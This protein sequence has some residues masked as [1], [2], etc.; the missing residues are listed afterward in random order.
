AR[1]GLPTTPGSPAA[2][3]RRVA[4]ALAALSGFALAYLFLIGLG[5][6]SIPGGVY[7]VF[8]PA[9]GF[10]LAV[11]LIEPIWRWPALVVVAT[12]VDAASA[13]RYPGLEAIAAVLPL[14]N[15]LTV[16]LNAVLMR[17]IFK[18]RRNPLDFRELAF[19]LAVTAI[20]S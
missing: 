4:R 13:R 1:Q 17:W 6:S 2:A 11:L 9:A 18:G 15:S 8:R 14:V 3:V 12:T 10:F 7:N 20:G 5:R 16:V 19:F